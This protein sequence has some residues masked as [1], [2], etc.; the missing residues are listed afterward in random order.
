MLDPYITFGIRGAVTLANLAEALTNMRHLVD[1]LQREIA[2]EAA[3]TWLVDDLRPGSAIATF[4]PQGPDVE[5]AAAIVAAYGAI[6]SALER[7]EEIPYSAP[8]RSSARRLSLALREGVT[9]IH[10]RTPT[11]HATLSEPAPSAPPQSDLQYSLGALRGT[12]QTL[13]ERRGLC[14]FL[15]DA[16][17]DQPV[18]CYITREQQEQAADTWGKRV[19]V[20]GRIG[21]HRSDG[22]PVEIRDITGFRLVETPQPGDWRRII[23]ILP[24][25]EDAPPSEDVVRRLRS[26]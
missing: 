25:P 15:Y 22:R 9:A 20:L 4:R 3:L 7:G 13:T 24:A 1:A 8:V 6:G 18:R 21:R 14:V 10:F 5:S 11:I 23:G 16:L 2:P 17:F 26:A 19:I 12:V